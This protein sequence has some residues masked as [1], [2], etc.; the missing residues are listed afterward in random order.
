L[1]MRLGKIKM[2]RATHL[3]FLWLV[4]GKISYVLS[5]YLVMFE[6]YFLSNNCLEAS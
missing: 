5:S 1:H 2:W 6:T 3:I 4:R